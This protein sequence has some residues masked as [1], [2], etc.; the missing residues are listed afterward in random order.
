MG[1]AFFV[2]NTGCQMCDFLAQVGFRTLSLLL[3]GLGAGL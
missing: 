3:G 1:A 2:L